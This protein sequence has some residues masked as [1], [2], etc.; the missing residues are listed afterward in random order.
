MNRM[1]IEMLKLKSGSK[2]AFLVSSILMCVLILVLLFSI[3]HSAEPLC[4]QC[5]VSFLALDVKSSPWPGRVNVS[6]ALYTINLPEEKEPQKI[7]AALEKGEITLD[8]LKNIASLSPVVGENI[9]VVYNSSMGQQEICRKITDE[10][11]TIE[12]E[13]IINTAGCGFIVASFQPSTPSLTAAEST[14][15]Y[16]VKGEIPF[17][18]A[19]S[20]ADCLT[21]FLILG[22]LAAALYASGKT[23]LAALDI[24]TPKRPSA[25][26]YYPGFLHIKQKFS[27]QVAPR[28]EKRVVNKLKKALTNISPSEIKKINELPLKKQKEKLMKLAAATMPGMVQRVRLI[29]DEIATLRVKLASAKTRKDKREI[30][31]KIKEL[32]KE[33]RQY[34]LIKKMHAK[35]E[36]W[37]AD[38]PLMR[39]FPTKLTP[40]QVE[41]LRKFWSD[42]S[43]HIWTYPSLELRPEV[44]K[45]IQK[46]ADASKKKATE[47]IKKGEDAI[48]ALRDAMKEEAAKLLENTKTQLEADKEIAA[49]IDKKGGKLEDAVGVNLNQR[50]EDVDSLID[51]F[52]PALGTQ[53]KLELAREGLNKAA[54]SAS[55]EEK[56][57]IESSIASVNKL[58]TEFEA[59]MKRLEEDVSKTYAHIRKEEEAIAEWLKPLLRVG[60]IAE[61]AATTK[62]TAPQAEAIARAKERLEVLQKPEE[63]VI[64]GVT[65][66]LPPAFRDRGTK[67]N[68]LAAIIDRE[69]EELKKR[70]AKVIGVELVDLAIK[71]NGQI[72]AINI[73]HGRKFEEGSMA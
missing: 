12:C 44:I 37:M 5:E 27:E 39:S 66:W 4:K 13:A 69:K 71:I 38:S 32:E 14:A 73:K 3:Q 67:A 20:S 45:F 21:L 2:K 1:E 15:P 61:I 70:S 40:D 56:A 36:K 33:K 58:N 52:S 50:K 57:R 47:R 17:G 59:C 19:I 7:I 18:T 46:L 49:L 9:T 54:E 31:D 42:E 51:R 72:E 62:L 55:E 35:L 6:V 53:L 24:T 41:A 60:S 30:L 22:I 23:P 26:G 29:T 48:I 25:G 8:T 34:D 43:H 65:L 16:C 63:F 10:N 11:G 64:S 68:E 28:L